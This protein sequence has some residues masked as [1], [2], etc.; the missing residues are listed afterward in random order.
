MTLI[1][2]HLFRESYVPVRYKNSANTE[3]V[4]KPGQ[5]KEMRQQ[6]HPVN[7]SKKIPNTEPSA[8]ASISTSICPRKLPHVGRVT[9]SK[10]LCESVGI[11]LKSHTQA[12]TIFN[13]LYLM[14]KSFFS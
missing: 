14:P 7:H 13:H 6:S 2:K 11:Q 12:S 1:S 3:G 4:N 8:L 10:S 5:G 9:N